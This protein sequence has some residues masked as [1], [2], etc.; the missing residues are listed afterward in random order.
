MGVGSIYHWARYRQHRIKVALRRRG[1]PVPESKVKKGRVKFVGLSY[2]KCGRTWTRLMINL[3]E[4]KHYGVPPINCVHGVRYS[5]YHLP[6]MGFTH[7]IKTRKPIATHHLELPQSITGVVF[8]TRDPVR[9]L[10]SYY[11]DLRY[12]HKTYTDNLSNFIRDSD[13]GLLRYI[14]FLEY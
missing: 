14:E 6:R 9:V 10:S 7:G 2:P 8:V 11:H 13:F 12:R 3:A 5:Q 4:S 1:V